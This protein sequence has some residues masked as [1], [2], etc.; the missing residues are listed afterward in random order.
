MVRPGGRMRIRSTR[1]GRD[2]RACGGPCRRPRGGRTPVTRD[3]VGTG[4]GVRPAG[5]RPPVRARPPDARTPRAARTARRQ[6]AAAGGIDYAKVRFERVVRAVRIT[7][8]ILIDGRL[9]EAAWEAA[10]PAD[11]FTQWEPKPGMPA[12]DDTEVRFLYDDNNLYIGARCFDSEPTRLTVNELRKDFDAGQDDG[13]GIVLDT[14]HDRQTG[15]VFQT[16]PAGARRDVQVS[17]DGEQT[18][19][20]WDGVWDVQTSIDERG[21]IAE[22]VIPFKTLRFSSAPTLE[23]GLNIMRRVRRTNEDT[24]WVP[25]ERRYRLQRVS[26]AG[27]LTGLTTV[28]PGRN[29]KLKPF[30]VFNAVKPEDLPREFDGDGGLDVKYGLTKSMTLDL[31]YR[32]DF[33]QVEVDQQVVNLTRFRVF[34]PEKREFFLE[35]SGAFAV[36]G[37]GRW[38]GQNVIPFFS[39]RIGLGE[40]ADDETVPIPIVGGARASG[41]V[42]TYD[43]GLLTMRT[44]RDG[45][46]PAT[47]TW[48]SGPQELPREL[49]GGRPS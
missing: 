5:D 23:W 24:Y 38:G 30:A 10:Q 40:N 11:R 42:G 29:F 25:L 1:D 9:D 47:P 46:T 33:S 4:A 43:L 22:I 2:G 6:P 36:G 44:G 3:R 39:R 26:V 32:T 49:H 28:N 13:F 16:N 45:V 20:D 12:T 7:E 27:T 8:P 17:Q 31:T 19:Q 35:N 34:F 41:K 14:L 37:G 48:W 21:W 18:N 15:F